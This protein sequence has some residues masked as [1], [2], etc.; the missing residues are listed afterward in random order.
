MDGQKGRLFMK[1]FKR[2]LSLV[3]ALGCVYSLVLPAIACSDTDC[4]TE[5]CVSENEDGVIMPRGPVCPD[6]GST[7]SRTETGIR[8]D[9]SFGYRC[10]LNSSWGHFQWVMGEH[11]FCLDCDAY[12]GTGRVYDKGYVCS[13][14]PSNYYPNHGP[15]V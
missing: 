13:G 12:V 2:I 14:D 10:S 3:L 5:V 8:L 11:Y 7:S 15:E 1:R 4:A 9:R 6:C